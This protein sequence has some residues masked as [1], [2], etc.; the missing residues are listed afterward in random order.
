MVKYN[1][2]YFHHLT[3]YLMICKKL[4]SRSGF[5]SYLQ[6]RTANPANLASI[7]C[8]VLICPLKAIVEIKFFAYFY[9]PLVKAFFYLSCNQKTK[10]DFKKDFNTL[11]LAQ[12]KAIE[13]PNKMA[14]YLDL[15][16]GLFI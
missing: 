13:K 3:T 7:L 8:H 5:L 1:K 2:K 14:T 15:V 11:C 16:F 10:K 4:K 9:S 12:K 6:V